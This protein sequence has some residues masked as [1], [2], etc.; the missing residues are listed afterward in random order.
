[1]DDYKY[2]Q[3]PSEEHTNNDDVY[4]G[5]MMDIYMGRSMNISFGMSTNLTLISDETCS[6]DIAAI[7]CVGASINGYKIG[8]A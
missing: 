4:Q 8:T 1:M 2:S 7:E 6:L 5:S 3:L